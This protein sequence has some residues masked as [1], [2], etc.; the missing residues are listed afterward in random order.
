[1]SVN[2]QPR[3]DH[4]LV[5]ESH[6]ETPTRTHPPSTR[7]QPACRVSHAGRKQAPSDEAL[8]AQ[9]RSLPYLTGRY[10]EETGLYNLFINHAGTHIE[11]LLAF[12]D[13]GRLPT[14]G[15]F[16]DERVTQ[17]IARFGGDY[18]EGGDEYELYAAFDPADRVGVL[19]L[20]DQDGQRLRLVF[21]EDNAPP[22]LLQVANT[23][24]VKV[25]DEPAL[26]ERYLTSIGVRSIF[27][28]NHWFALTPQQVLHLESDFVADFRD[29]FDT[30]LGRRKMGIAELIEHYFEQSLSVPS[31]VRRQ[32]NRTNAEAIDDFL[33]KLTSHVLSR[34]VQDGGLHIAHMDALVLVARFKLG[35]L[36][37]K[38]GPTAHPDNFVRIIHR[39]CNEQTGAFSSQN[40]RA[41]G[42]IPTDVICEFE[43]SFE[44]DGAE[45]DAGPGSAGAW[46]GQLTLKKTKG[47][48]FSRFAGKRDVA[49]FPL[50]FASYGGGWGLMVST[51]M[52]G[53]GFASSGH[54]WLA[55][56]IPG[57]ATAGGASVDVALG[58]GL[59]YGVTTMILSGDPGAGA[60][61]V[62][63]MIHFDPPKTWSAAMT[64]GLGG[65]VGGKALHGRVLHPEAKPTADDALEVLPKI[66]SA[67][68]LKHLALEEKIHYCT[69][70]AQLTDEAKR[71]IATVAALE[72]PALYAAESRL[73]IKGYADRKGKSDDNEVLALARAANVRTHLEDVLVVALD[74]GLIKANIEA[75]GKGE[76]VHG[77]DDV[78]N[79]TFRRVKMVLDG[80]LI[81]L[82]TGVPDGLPAEE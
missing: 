82:L 19:G 64:F 55:E 71:Y 24:A 27:R 33:A 78:P 34:R 29:D 56:Q 13:T 44:L 49:T 70:D 42:F 73:K 40:L 18:E 4:E 81:L 60:P 6:S 50:A 15:K 21:F 45:T 1:M 79:P 69:N 36:T 80:T 8:R 25:N 51:F 76:I 75:Y 63:L 47:A 38:P 14:V 61:S 72:L 67:S 9:L 46:I 30:N 54:D 37:A 32:V 7:L 16:E 66:G 5:P 11:C 77:P 68:Y 22:K 2:S 28:T 39:I 41:Y 10:V 23:I 31:F 20:E 52:S 58:I 48:Q 53:S 35:H 3:H 65:S 59:S 62:P 74:K 26:F 57:P 12:V 43:A 17:S